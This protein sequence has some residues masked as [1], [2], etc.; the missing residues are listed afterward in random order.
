MWGFMSGQ[1]RALDKT[2]LIQQLSEKSFLFR[3]MDRQWL[4]DRLLPK[5][6]IREKLYSSRPIFNAF[7]PDTSLEFL[8]VVLAGG[9]VV[10]RST[11]LDRII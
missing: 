3:E 1:A 10:I 6:L 5:G 8:Y 4:S 11:P 7:Q 9:P 2:N